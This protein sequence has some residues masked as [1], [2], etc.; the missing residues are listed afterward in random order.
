M[1]TI[2]IDGKKLDFEPGQLILDV[3]H[4]NGIK[5]PHYCYHPSLSAVAFGDVV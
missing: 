5:I 4:D 2:T 1:P 3:A